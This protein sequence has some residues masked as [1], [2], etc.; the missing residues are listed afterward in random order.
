MDDLSGHLINGSGDW[1]VLSLPAIADVDERVQIG[2][3]EF[4]CRRI[5]EALHPAHESLETLLKLRRDLGTYD[6]G[7]Q[8][9]QSPIPE[10]GAMLKSHWFRFYDEGL[11]RGPKDKL[12]QS[13]DIAAKDG[14]RSE[15]AAKWRQPMTSDAIHAAVAKITMALPKR[16]RSERRSGGLYQIRGPLLAQSRRSR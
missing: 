12:I 2:D 11:V 9:Q 8:Y 4:Y 7:A 13:W 1:E 14:L 3:D 15:I 6:F 16:L 10:G 5:G